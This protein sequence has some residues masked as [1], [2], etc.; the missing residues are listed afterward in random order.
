MALIEC[1]E[2]GN[3]GVSSSAANCPKCGFPIHEHFLRLKYLTDVDR[4]LA[5]LESRW[6]EIRLKD[7]ADYYHRCS[8]IWDT[9]SRC[10]GFTEE[11]VR[12]VAPEKIK[13][14]HLDALEHAV[15][16]SRGPIKQMENGDALFDRLI[17]RIMH[18][19]NSKR[20]SEGNCFMWRSGMDWVHILNV[21]HLEDLSQEALLEVAAEIGYHRKRCCFEHHVGYCY[22]MIRRHISPENEDELLR[23]FGVGSAD[24]FNRNYLIKEAYEA[25]LELKAKN[26]L[27]I[28]PSLL[29]NQYEIKRQEKPV[30]DPQSNDEAE[31]E[32]TSSDLDTET[33]FVA[34]SDSADESG[35]P[36]HCPACGKSGTWKKVGES[37]KG[38]SVGKAAAGGILLGPLGII[39]GALGQKKQTY[40]C[41][42]CGFR[43]DYKQ[44]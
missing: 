11:S 41:T 5:N 13:Y 2:C 44:S 7:A 9:V 31:R 19:A 33:S 21:I 4:V 3:E 10:T 18:L 36:S 38:F 17:C 12:N 8:E 26:E 6:D 22:D 37:R 15:E 24:D 14:Q 42:S 28:S 23:K 25:W 40:Y 39:G 27:S 1:P 29:L 43:E 30:Y 20:F 16:D 35:I 32:Q 34:A